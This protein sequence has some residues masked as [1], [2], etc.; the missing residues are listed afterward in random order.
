MPATKLKLHQENA[1]ACNSLCQRATAISSYHQL[2]V[3]AAC[4]RYGAAQVCAERRVANSSPAALGAYRTLHMAPRPKLGPSPEKRHKCDRC[5][6]SFA[7][8]GHL[9]VHKRTHTGEKPYRCDQCGVAFAQSSALVKHKRTHT[10]EKPYKCDHCGAAFRR[11]S[12]L[13]EHIRRRHRPNSARTTHQFCCHSDCT[14]GHYLYL[15]MHAWDGSLGSR[16]RVVDPIPS[17]QPSSPLAPRLT[18]QAHG[19]EAVQV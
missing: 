15:A 2:I 10:G 9:V 6:A 8:S 12:H 5:S 1:T 16:V 13:V 4:N 19:R 17:V 18:A 3:P 7:R 11:S 14:R